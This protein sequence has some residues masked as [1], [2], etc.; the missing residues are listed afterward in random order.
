M[1]YEA[2]Q[3]SY[4][5]QYPHA[6]NSIIVCDGEKAGRMLSA[7]AGADIAVVDLV[8]MPAYRNRGLGTALLRDLQNVASEE[9]LGLCL[10]SW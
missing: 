10:H 1:Q 6:S 7:R 3:N 9:G 8:L 4:S 5:L 2:Q